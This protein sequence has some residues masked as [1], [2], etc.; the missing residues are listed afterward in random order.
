MEQGRK[1]D[2]PV[3]KSDFAPVDD[4]SQGVSGRIAQDMLGCEIQMRQDRLR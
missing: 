2:G 4:T 1:I 3:R